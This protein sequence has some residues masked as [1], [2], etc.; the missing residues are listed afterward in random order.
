MLNLIYLVKIRV[1]SWLFLTFS[2][3][4]WGLCGYQFMQNK[5]N[6]RKSQM[7]VTLVVTTNCSE[8]WSMDTWSKQTQSKPICYSNKMNTT[9]LLT[10]HYE[11]KRLCRRGEKQTQSNP[12]KLEARR[13]GSLPH[14]FFYFKRDLSKWG[15]TRFL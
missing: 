8:K 3:V 4:P 6:F 10:K 15:I 14:Q 5:P 9:F 1:N 7:V 13:V 2:F 11:N 12:N